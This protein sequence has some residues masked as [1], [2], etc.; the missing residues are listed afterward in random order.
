[1]WV[2]D[3]GGGLEEVEELRKF[4]SGAGPHLLVARAASNRRQR[5]AGLPAQQVAV[6]CMICSQ[7]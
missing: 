2:W 5:Q 6:T 7:L 1:V 3:L 4:R